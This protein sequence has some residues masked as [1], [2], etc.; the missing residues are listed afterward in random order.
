MSIWLVFQSLLKKRL[1]L[2]SDL[3]L[4]DQN[5]VWVLEGKHTTIFKSGKWSFGATIYTARICPWT[6]RSTL[7]WQDLT[8]CIWWNNRCHLLSGPLWL[9]VQSR[10]RTRLRIAISISRFGFALV[11]KGFKHYSTTIARLSL[12]SGLEQGLSQRGSYSGRGA[13][14]EIV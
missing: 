2:D 3:K 11:L 6:T 9:R 4:S 10:S 1:L 12:L 8:C 5:S 14:A 13:E 7:F